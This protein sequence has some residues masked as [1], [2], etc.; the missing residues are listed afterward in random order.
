MNEAEYES[1]AANPTLE[2]LEGKKVVPQL[3]KPKFFGCVDASNT[4]PRSSTPISD[5]SPRDS[6]GEPMTPAL[7]LA[8]S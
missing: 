8:A 6:D 7:R 2:H 5:A 3:H 4:S 1:F